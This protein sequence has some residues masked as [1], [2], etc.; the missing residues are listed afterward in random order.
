MRATATEQGLKTDWYI[1]ERSDPE[2]ATVAAAKYLKTL[3][4]MFDGDWH[5]VLAAYNGGLGRVQRAMK[6]SGQRRL[7]VA[8]EQHALPPARDARVRAAH[9][10]RDHRVEEPLAVRVRHHRRGADRVREGA[11]CRGPSTCAGSRSGP[12]GASTRSRRSIP[13]CGAGRRRSSTEY[14]LKVPDG[15]AGA[16]QG[17]AGIGVTRRARGADVVHGQ[18]GRDDRHHRAQAQGQPRRPRRGEPTSRPSPG[19]GRA[20]RWSSRA[21]RR[22]CSPPTAGRRRR[23]RWPRAVSPVPRRWQTTPH[24]RAPRRS[25]W[26]RSRTI[27]SRPSRTA[28]SAATR[29]S[30][31]RSSTTPPWPRSRA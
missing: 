31:S 27:P 29:S 21:R 25:R 26:P 4:N 13:S 30:G 18:E 28:S 19:S 12:G 23:R 22:R 11:A 6:R 17:A 3:H 24:V 8:V 16:F 20:R 9:P 15:T 2:K 7:L 14:E 5:L 1:D 10:G